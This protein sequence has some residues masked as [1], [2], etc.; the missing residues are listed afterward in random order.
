M[1]K[2]TLLENKNDSTFHLNRFEE[3]DEANFGESEANHLRSI[4]LSF[5]PFV[6]VL[7]RSFLRE[8]K[9]G[10]L[11]FFLVEKKMVRARFGNKGQ[12]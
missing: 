8:E 11:L 1:K 12:S 9:K 4:F 3:K 7:F 6:S 10:F 5:P 2:R